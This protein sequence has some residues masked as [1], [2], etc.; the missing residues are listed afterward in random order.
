MA[1]SVFSGREK[2]YFLAVIH[3]NL[4]VG[5]PS[6]HRLVEETL[7]EELVEARGSLETIELGKSGLEILL[8]CVSKLAFSPV[9]SAFAL[10]VFAS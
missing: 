4:L 9:A 8:G 7:N 10:V 2:L 5:T 6:R 3:T 1:G